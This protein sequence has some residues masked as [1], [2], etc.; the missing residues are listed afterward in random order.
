MSRVRSTAGAYGEQKSGSAHR[1][2][3]GRTAGQAM[4]C[5]QDQRKWASN[6]AEAL[7]EIAAMPGIFEHLAFVLIDDKLGFD[8]QHF[9]GVPEFVGLRRQ[10]FVITTA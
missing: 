9:H 6:Q 5:R 7:D 1:W 2:L 4:H 3:S 10:N 8:T